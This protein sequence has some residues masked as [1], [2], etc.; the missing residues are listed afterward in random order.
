MEAF[1]AEVMGVLKSAG[2][3]PLMERRDAGAGGMNSK[4]H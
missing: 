3:L 4:S 2:T 1:E